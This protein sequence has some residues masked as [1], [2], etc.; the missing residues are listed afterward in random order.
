MAGSHVVAG[1][2]EKLYRLFVNLIDNA[3]RYN[4][5][6][7]GKIMISAEKSKAGVCVEILNSG[8]EIPEKDLPK[9]FEQFYRIGKIPVS[10]PWR[11]RIGS[12]HRPKNSPAFIMGK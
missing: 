6:T 7:H 1:D 10:R 3:I 12:I 9:L 5:N 11:I 4:L 2:P 8:H